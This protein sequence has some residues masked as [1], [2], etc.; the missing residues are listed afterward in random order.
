MIKLDPNPPRVLTD[1]ECAKLI[2]GSIGL[3]LSV[4]DAETVK[5]AFDWWGEHWHEGVGAIIA[6]M[7]PGSRS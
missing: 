6:N 5:R 2:G 3:C 4:A 1:R 7:P